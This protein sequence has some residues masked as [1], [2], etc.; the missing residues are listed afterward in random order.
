M[1]MENQFGIVTA[2]GS[3]MGRAGAVR[4]ARE[5]A[6][7]AVVDRSAADAHAVA[8][9]IQAAGGAALA[10]VGDLRDD[11]FAREIVERTAAHFGALD[12]LWNHVGHPGPALFEG[13]EMADYELAMDLNVRT[14]L[15]STA[16]A[17]PHMRRRGG[18]SV[19]FTSSVAGIMGSQFSPVYSAAKFAVVGLARALAKRH[20]KENIRFNAICPGTVDTP[21]L[22]TFLAR[23]DS[24]VKTDP[25]ELVKQRGT[26]NPIGRPAQP[27]EIAN[28]ALFLLSK[29]ASFVTGAVLPVD[30]GASA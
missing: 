29:E 30:G 8:E 16:E 5:G 25:E 12:F 23:P 1:R 22:R 13:V 21:M 20:A 27:H 28:A 18:G 2:A 7:V 19:L 4:L 26:A 10:L 17:L 15:V 3:G 14:V 9:E 24:G 6:G 11:G